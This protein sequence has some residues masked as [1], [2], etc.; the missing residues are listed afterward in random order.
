MT[1]ECLVASF[2]PHAALL[3]SVKKV[4]KA[5]GCRMTWALWTIAISM[6]KWLHYLPELERT[7]YWMHLIGSASPLFSSIVSSQ[8]HWKKAHV[9]HKSCFRRCTRELFRI[10]KQTMHSKTVTGPECLL[11][12]SQHP[13]FEAV[14]FPLKYGSGFSVWLFSFFTLL[15]DT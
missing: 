10:V 13:V 9:F 15:S 11:D 14:Y 4:L 12:C 6:R 5:G 3:P 2:G 8:L 1:A 7:I